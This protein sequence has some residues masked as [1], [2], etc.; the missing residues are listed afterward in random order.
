L[1]SKDAKGRRQKAEKTGRMTK[2]LND[3]NGRNP[4]IR[5]KFLKKYQKRV[6]FDWP[7]TIGRKRH[8]ADPQLTEWN[9]WAKKYYHIQKGIKIIFKII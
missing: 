7:N 6:L 3:S 9:N 2:C 5:Q 8:L 4:Q 1:F